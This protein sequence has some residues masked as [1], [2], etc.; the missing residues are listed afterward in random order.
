[1]KTT[2]NCFNRVLFALLLCVGVV[3]VSCEEIQP[4]AVT[5]VSLNS[6]SMELVEGTTQTLVATVSPSN[7]ENQKVIW[8]SSNSSVASVTDGVVTAIKVGTATITVKTDDGAKTATCNITVVAKEIPVT[9]V[10]LVQTEIELMEGDEFTLNAT[11]KPDNATNK[12]LIWTSSDESVATV[13]DGKVTAVM[14]GTATITVKTD[15]GAKTATCNVTVLHD[16]SN[17]AIIF[18]DEIMKELCI[19]AFDTNGDDELSYA[20]AAAVTDLSQMK[21]TDKSFKSFDEFEYFT[22]VTIVPENYFQGIGIKS[23]ILPHSLKRIGDYAFNGCSSL[24][25]ITIP[26][27]VTDIGPYTFYG[28]SSLQSITIPESVTSIHE[29]TFSGCSS[30]QSITIPESVT[31][32]GQNAFRGC[33]SLQS[34]TIPESVT[35]IGDAAFYFCSSLKEIYVKSQDCPKVGSG[36]FNINASSRKIYVPYKVR[37][38]YK[39]AKGWSEY[40][41]DIVGYDYENNKVVE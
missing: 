13:D 36:T 15:E 21:L 10:S 12:N 38:A 23:I 9:S 18:A 16:Q 28:C 25:S 2:L 3:M 31:N 32:I 11:V 27:S 30:L 29:Y 14:A 24:Q 17:D 6:T 39:K 8:S 20:E 5:S 22:G 7:A 41:A 37:D 33:S 35:D 4:I 40:A 34:I 26:E 1:M 19:T